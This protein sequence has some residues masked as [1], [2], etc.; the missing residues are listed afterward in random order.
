MLIRVMI[1]RIRGENLL[2]QA[3]SPKA[4]D[5]L[6]PP[7]FT[8]FFSVKWKRRFRWKELHWKS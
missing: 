2:A 6:A 5:R 8:P 1:E 7:N 4:A 3:L